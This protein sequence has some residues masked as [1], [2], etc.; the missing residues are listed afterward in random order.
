MAG[1]VPTSWWRPVPSGDKTAI[2]SAQQPHSLLLPV[3]VLSLPKAK[4]IEAT[5]SGKKKG[6]VHWGKAR[7]GTRENDAIIVYLVQTMVATGE[8]P[9]LFLFFSLVITK[10]SFKTPQWDGDFV[11]VFL[12]LSI[13][14]WPLAWWL[15]FN[16]G[17]VVLGG[18]RCYEHNS[19]SPERTILRRKYWMEK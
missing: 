17:K 8:M 14:R 12:R 9:L 19:S 7:G 4:E 10:R 18:V 3:E 16:W 1:L 15:L 13:S 6:K 2:V 11:C 5:A